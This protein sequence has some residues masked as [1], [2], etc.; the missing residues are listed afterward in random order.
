[1]VY[2]HLFPRPHSQYIDGD[3][4]VAMAFA[5]FEYALHGP[6]HPRVPLLEESNGK[7]SFLSISSKGVAW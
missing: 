3:K 2:Y 6:Y 1:M 4:I 7:A 5:S